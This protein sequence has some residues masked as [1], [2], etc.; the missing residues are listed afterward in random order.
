MTVKIGIGAQLRYGPRP[1]TDL[2]SL[3]LALRAWYLLR[4]RRLPWRDDPSPYR[5]WVS[6][7]MLQQTQVVTVIPYFERFMLAFPTVAA[8]ASAP[9]SD[10]M[11]LWSGLGY[12]RR[13]RMLHAAAKAIVAD[14]DGAL[15]ASLEGLTSLPGVGRYTAGA[16]A[17]IAFGVRAPVLDGNVA[18]V[19][20]RLTAL[21]DP[22]DGG[23]GQKALWALADAL[24]PAD[25]PSTHNQA[26]MEL[27]ALVCTPRS[28]SCGECPWSS[29]CVARAERCAE[30]LPLKKPKAAPKAV[31][32]VA[33]YLLEDL[34]S[35]A[36][37]LARRPAD[38]L[39]G[40]LW[41]LP[42]IELASAR[43]AKKP[44]LAAAFRER[45]GLTVEVGSHVGSVAHQFTH[46][47][48]TLEIYR[49]HT[50]AGTPTP[51]WYTDARFVSAS[52]PDAVPLSTLTRKVIA[53]VH[54]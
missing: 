47:T 3:R 50:L 20:A 38:G 44:A 5:V 33:G 14:H 13:A 45:L 25:D 16:I 41:E 18:R 27:G 32:A 36:L 15:P 4:K 24:V 34:A 10:V 54:A 30:E 9:E 51:S 12:Y 26:M 29:R 8:L 43:A 21:R 52:T 46:R 28:P 31:H 11:T 1:M 19:L 48:L 42:A 23:A 17:S 49:V 2:P 40:G 37:L 35:D 53:A 39:L 6:E 22:V 7:I